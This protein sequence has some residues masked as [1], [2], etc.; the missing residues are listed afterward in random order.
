M[1]RVR[2]PLNPRRRAATKTRWLVGGF[3]AFM[4]SLFYFANPGDTDYPR[5]KSI[6]TDAALLADVVRNATHT[7][8][9][10]PS[11][12]SD[13]QHITRN[14]GVERSPK[15]H[16]NLPLFDQGG[17]IFFLHIAKTGGVTIRKNFGEFEGVRMQRCR[18][19]RQWSQLAEEIDNILTR[20]T[21]NKD[22]LFIE[23]HGLVPGLITLHKRLHRWRAD[24]ARHQT[25]FFTFTLVREPVSFYISYFNYFWTDQCK[26]LCERPIQAPTE[27]N[28]LATAIP[29]HQALWLTRDG[30][31]LHD[32]NQPVTKKEFEI[33]QLYMQQDLDWIGTT[34]E[35]Q[36]TTLPLLSYMLAQNFSSS[37]PAF[38][39]M[40]HNAGLQRAG[41]S[42]DT[43]GK[44]RE[45]AP[46]DFELYDA[47]QRDFSLE[48][49]KNLP[50]IGTGL[51]LSQ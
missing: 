13:A 10:S 6:L 2:Q 25:S 22:T 16:R 7:T 46:L 49:W 30:R 5:S 29:N 31:D 40:A 8:S 45:L 23:F 14:T 41:L 11:T 32:K 44:L 50:R 39:R 48:M 36:T 33:V 34:G 15:N 28:L 18:G 9:T 4:I 17:V 1:V 21:T 3:G 37:L 38:N 42:E 12:T 27:E 20:K 47:V 26:T 43:L 35:M 51:A 19:E 24:A